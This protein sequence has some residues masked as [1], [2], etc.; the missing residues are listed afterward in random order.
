M[1]EIDN[2]NKLTQIISNWFENQLKPIVRFLI[3]LRV[4]LTIAVASGYVFTQIDQTIEVYRVIAFDRNVAQAVF[5]TV[6]VVLLSLGVWFAARLLETG[7][8]DRLP[9]FYNPKFDLLYKIAPRFLGAIPLACLAYGTWD[10]QK[11]LQNL[12]APTPKI[13]L[14]VWMFSNIVLLG[15]L[16]CL[17]I[18][19]IELLKKSKFLGALASNKKGEGLFG[20]DFENIFVNIACFVF[21]VL[22]FPMLVAAQDAP[23]SFGLVAVFL[24][25]V[26]FNVALFSW[27]KTENSR[28]TVVITGLISLL[29]SLALGLILPPTFL[30]DLLGSVSVV[31][32]SLTI[33]VVVFSTI[34]DWSLQSKIPGITILIV[35]IVVSSYFNFNDN[36]RFRQF[37]KPEKSVLPTLESSFQ[38]WLANRP[39]LD[40]FSNKPYPVYIAAAQGGGIYAAYHAA[41]A[42]TKLT[43]Y[44]PSFPQ[45]I[46]A[47]SSVSGG[48]LGASAFSSL[49]KFGG[50]S[51]KSLSQTASKM[52]SSDLLTP[53]LTMGLFPDLIQRFMFFPIYDWDRGTGLEVA[54]EKAW[55]KL[56]LPNQDNPLRQSFY[57]HWKPEGIAPAL[58]LN[59]TVVETGDRQA[60][61]PFQINLPNKENIA[62]DEP[63]LDLK[64]STAAGLSARFPYFTPVGWYQRS[65]DK[66]KLH[67]ADGGY[68]DNSGIPTALDIGRSLQRLKGYGTTFEIIYLSLIDGQLNEPTTQLK[69][70]GLNEVLSPVRALFRARK[71]RSRS[72]VELSAFTVNDGIDDPLKYKFRI[73]FLKKS[74]DGVK[75]PLGW[76]IS[77]R[78]RKFIDRQTP[79]PN[80]PATACEIEKFRQGFANGRVRMNDNHNPCVIGSIGNDLS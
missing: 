8:K 59:T 70:V 6:L 17:I 75:L 10:T 25:V 54:F 63:D 24:L 78:S 23:W 18:N 42:F 71:S 73:L 53:L 69:S 44:F 31:A 12:S 68:F 76:L 56:S 19:R 72:A 67:L 38:Q 2:R 3:Y 36:H 45:H 33:L 9:E 46:F 77:E 27:Q 11:T 13:F 37:S 58:V 34:Y 15:I 65:K 39:D 61:G 28:N 80:D 5:S 41:T 49:V 43:E 32:L 26:F 14:L 22:S 21:I 66:S 57:Q 50:I 62:I 48:S 64:L 52:F 55:D 74:G 1:A 79:D 40:R 60:I 29:G 4:P 35:L 30:P 47:I 20:Q 16:G 7:Y 51:G